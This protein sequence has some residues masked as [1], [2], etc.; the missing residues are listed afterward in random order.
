MLDNLANYFETAG[1]M[2][3]GH[4][5]LWTPSLLWIYVVSDFVIAASYFSIPFALWYFARKRPDVPFRW[6]FLMFGAFV[7]ACGTTHLFAIWNIW[8]ADYWADAGVKAVTA[9]ASAATAILLWPLIPKALSIPSHMQLEHA[10]R[11]LQNEVMR[12][13]EAE[14]ALLDANEALERR[15]AVRTAEL[16]A[17][18]TSLRAREARYLSVASSAKDSLVTSDAAGRIVGWNPSAERLFGYAETEVIGQPLTLLMPQRFQERHLDGMRRVQSGGE[19]HIIGKAAELVG[20]RKDATEFPLELTLADWTVGDGRFF[21]GF[22]RDITERKAAEAKIQRLTQLYAALSQCSEAIV[23]CAGE[24]ELFRQVCRAAVQ[25]GGMKM[26][27]IGIVDQDTR[28]VRLVASFGD[29][30][31]EYLQGIE[32]SADAA[33]PL[34]RGPTGTAVREN[35]PVWRQDFQHDPITAPWHERRARFGWGASASLPLRR[36]GV[37]VGVLTLYADEA[38]AFDEAARQLLVEMAT[39]ISFA[40]DN[41]AREAARERAEKDLRAAEEQFRGLVEQSIA[42]TY[43]IQDGKFAYVNPRFLEIFGYDSA[44]EL[45]GRDAISLVAEQ[46]RGTVRENMRQRAEGAAANVYYSFA[47]VRKDGVVIDIGVHGTR[48]THGGRPAIIGLVQDISEKKRADAQIQRYLTQLETAFMSTV[49]VATT[50]SELRDPYTAGHERRV[51]KIAAAIG[52]ELGFND[53]RIEGLRVAG[54]LHDIGKITIPAEILS[55]PGKLTPV[56]FQLIQVHP[57]ASFDVLKDVEF[58]WPV[59]EVALQ[60]HERMDGSGYPQGLKGEAILLEARILA[61]ADVIEAM[62]SHRP[63]RAG[64][65]IEA[66]LAEIE[67]GRGSSY[68]ADVANACLRLFRERNY[69]LPS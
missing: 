40:L 14:S 62:S 19:R 39:E 67:R 65:G 25:F 66:A 24:E 52:A 17:A 3:H 27:W 13:N 56:E 49:E 11:E 15:V 51:G 69:Q 32:I 12:R 26:A 20:R 9:S 38:G 16:E 57:Q 23:R 30:A 6:I 33:S 54:Y 7:L 22:I 18:N 59:A 53:R 37:P 68:D 21:T 50:L 4:C 35:Q 31:D 44:D 46:D 8:H 60:H 29:R 1:F 45:S 63:Y 28:M 58:P 5:F 41:F 47:A 61:V 10:N 34:G 64:L 55:K 42:G 2:P 48:A 36:D 43:I